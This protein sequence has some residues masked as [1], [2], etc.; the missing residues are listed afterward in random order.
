[1]IGLNG[2]ERQFRRAAAAGALLVVP[3]LAFHA[4]A[5]WAEERAPGEWRNCVDA[6]MADYNACLMD[7]AS[8]FSRMICDFSWELDVVYCTAKAIG[9]IRGALNPT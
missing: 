5:A 6:A 1:M 8:S 4:Q 7:A 9:A 3:L 2:V